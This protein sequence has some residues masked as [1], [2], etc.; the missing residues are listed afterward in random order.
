MEHAS[1]ADLEHAEL[2]EDFF[3]DRNW[4]S[5]K[6]LRFNAMREGLFIPKPVFP[7]V[8]MALVDSGIDWETAR[9]AAG[10]ATMRLPEAGVSE[11]LARAREVLRAREAA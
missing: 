4:T 8:V 6:Q 1:L 9:Y 5:D 7:A 11:T 3:R 2:L 10:T